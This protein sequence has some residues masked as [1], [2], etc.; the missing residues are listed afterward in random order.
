MN[1]TLS[2]AQKEWL[3]AQVDAGHFGSIDH[4]VTVA[5]A[6]LIAI[7]FDDLAWAK[8]YVEDARTAVARGKV[9]T[10]EDALTDIDTYVG[11]FKP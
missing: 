10:L 2:P 11:T 9:S 7:D 3:E 4:A 1:I 5:I 8:P 6:G